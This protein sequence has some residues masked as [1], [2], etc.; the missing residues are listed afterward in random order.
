M[1]REKHSSLAYLRRSTGKQEISLPTQLEWAMTAA[2]K[3]G[4]RLDATPIDL[5]YMMANRLHSHK[6]IRLDNGISGSDLSRPGFRAL[7]QDAIKDSSISH[8]FFYKRDRFARPD[9]AIE[10][11]QLEKKLSYAGITIVHSDGV[12]LPIR[13]G[14]QNLMRDLQLMI[15]Y[16]QSGEELRKHAERMVIAHKQL[17]EGGFRCGG[18]APYGFVRVLVDA[19]GNMIEELPDGKV[20]R[21]PG[22]MCG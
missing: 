13:R 11:A 5:Q 4:V 20:V 1:T 12:S 22:C 15:A 14:E 19:N 3:Q 10:A 16:S 9:D 21:Q 7:L 2:A 6:S 8:V 17:A 18:I